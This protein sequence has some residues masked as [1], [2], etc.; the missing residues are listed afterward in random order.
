MKIE[1]QAVPQHGRGKGS[2]VCKIDMV[3][4]FHDRTRLAAKHQIL[5]RTRTGSVAKVP[6]NRIKPI[7]FARTR[8]GDQTS[9]ETN[10]FVRN[11][12]AAHQFL[13]AN[14]F[15]S[16]QD[17]AG[18][19]FHRSRCPFDNL[20]FFLDRWITHPK[21]EHKTIQLGFGKRIGPF[22]LDWVLSGDNKKWRRQT[23]RL[24]TN[25][26]FAFLH[27]LE[28]RRLG[29]GWRS[30][31]FVGQQKVRKDGPFHEL[32][33]VPP[34]VLIF[35]EHVGAGDVRRHQVG[36]ELNSSKLH[37]E[38]PGKRAAHERFT[39]TGNAKQKHVP[40]AKQT[41]QQPV[42]DFTLAND[43][44]GDFLLDAL[45]GLAKPFDDGYVI[46]CNVS[47]S[48]RVIGRVSR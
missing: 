3:T 48:V 11:R 29:F 39:Q 8:G 33:S 26:D 7:D 40:A 41:R 14:Y 17:L 2:D 24:P 37:V 36:G 25:G 30:I 32:H 10:D 27:R 9:G 45:A 12:H 18:F 6:M 31:D 46:G 4:A 15:F 13:Q 21:V 43:D 19:G 20:D 28:Q 1:N 42:D 16:I 38:R 44:F 34:G 47:N 23:I 35:L 5:R 22:H